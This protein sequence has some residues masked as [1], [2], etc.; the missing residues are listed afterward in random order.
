[1]RLPPS[2]A[3]LS[4]KASRACPSAGG[5]RKRRLPARGQ[6]LG[7]VDRPRIRAVGAVSRRP[8]GQDVAREG[9]ALAKNVRSLRLRGDEFFDLAPIPVR[10]LVDVD[11]SLAGGRPVVADGTGRDEGAVDGGSHGPD[12]PPAIP[13]EA[14]SLAERTQPELVSSKT[15]TEPALVTPERL[16]YLAPMAAE[17]P[18][19]LTARPKP[20]FKL[21]S[22]ATILA[23]FLP[24]T[25]RLLEDVDCTRVGHYAVGPASPHEQCATREGQRHSELV[26]RLGV[27]GGELGH[28]RPRSPDLL[29]DVDRSG[30]GIPR[31]RSSVRPRQPRLQREPRLSRT[32]RLRFGPKRAGLRSRSTVSRSARRRGPDP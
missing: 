14:T 1:M 22:G 28:L 31:C 13:S 26:A 27:A 10:V 30:L 20:S 32:C 9:K 3:T 19:K 7:E 2:M 4:P 11:G 12:C 8:D 6:T 24:A 16:S 21:P 18:S 29:E 5:E 15:Y 23:Q 17:A 25:A